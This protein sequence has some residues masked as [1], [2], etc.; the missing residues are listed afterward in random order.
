VDELGCVVRFTA[1]Y[2]C[3]IAGERVENGWGLSK[4]YRRLPIAK[5]CYLD[6]LT[7]KSVEHCLIQVTPERA[8]R[9]S[10]HC[11]KYMLAYQKVVNEAEGK[12]T[13]T[14][15]LERIE[16]LVDT[17]FVAAR[18]ISSKKKRKELVG[19]GPTQKDFN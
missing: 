14:E 9:F 5:K 1:R 12:S 19:S 16:M 2:H 4:I 13:A 15:S 17:C 10:R 7:K 18:T 6:A 11:R 8:R 3:E